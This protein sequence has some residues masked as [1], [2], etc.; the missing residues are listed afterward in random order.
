MKETYYII[1]TR[2]FKDY[3]MDLED[4][5]ETIA[6]HE[7][8]QAIYCVET[9]TEDIEDDDIEDSWNH[10]SLSAEERNR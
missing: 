3:A 6:L 2:H 4:L 5:A 9:I 8:D 1:K 7:K 10:P